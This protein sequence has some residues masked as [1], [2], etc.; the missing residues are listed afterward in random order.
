M[1]RGIHTRTP[2]R[3]RK[4]NNGSS[5]PFKKRRFNRGRKSNN[6]TSQSGFGGGIR[7]KSRKVSRSRWSRM[8]WNNTIQRTHY[9]SNNAATGTFNTPATT[10]SMTVSSSPALRFATQQFYIAGGGAIAPD[11][12]QP[13]PTFTGMFTV[14]GATIGLRLVNTFDTTAASQNTLNGMAYLIK[15][16]NN[17]TVANIP[18]TVVVGWDPTLIQDFKTLIGTIIYRKQFLLRDAESALIEYRLRV[19]NIDPGDY[20]NDRNTYY[21]I[22]IAGNVDVTAARTFTYTAYYNMS[23][24]ADA[25]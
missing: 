11:A 14:R 16:S 25:V 19:H 8:L 2:S 4:R 21:W 5:R 6:F 1:V 3:K 15:T 9:R 7:F 22:V 20:V 12:A 10:V 17:F 24:S 13:L 23:F 18:A